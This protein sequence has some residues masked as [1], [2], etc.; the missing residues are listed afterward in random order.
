MIL[1]L[2]FLLGGSIV[3][4]ISIISKTK[5]YILAGLIPLFPA[6]A[7]ISNYIIL[8]DNGEDKL[9]ETLLFSICSLIP[10]FMYLIVLFLLIGKVK[11][12]TAFSLSILS[13]IF[14]AF[15][16]YFFFKK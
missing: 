9:K 6:F 13:W 14:F 3:L 11:N 16:I 1:L 8:N 10:Y 5:F 4:L 12:F 15:A 7:L 2:K